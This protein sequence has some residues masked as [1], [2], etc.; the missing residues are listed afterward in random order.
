MRILVV[1]DE[2]L[3]AERLIELIE[4]FNPEYHVIDRLDS[5]ESTVS[6]LQK[7]DSPDL[8]FLD[9]H[10]ADG[11]S[12]E[13]FETVN[14]TA[15]IIFSTAYDQYAI[16]AFKVNSVDYLLK[17][18]EQKDLYQALIKFEKTQMSQSMSMNIGELV[19]SFTKK[20]KSRFVIKVGEHLRAVEI[21]NDHFF[22]SEEKI[23]YLQTNEGKRYIIDF[24]LDKVETMID[25][26]KY[27]RIN[28]KYLV[29]FPAIADI[30]THSNS[31]LR[32]V[33]VN[34]DD[35]DV[36]VSRERVQEFRSWL[37]V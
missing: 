37:D 12:F 10:L 29:S 18:V 14:V 23:T 33:L 15:P 1:E 16:Q 17:P 20:H 34:N 13:I 35:D 27:F 4:K 36:I 5:V 6:W 7:N 8:I 11:N 28:R 26:E 31:R 24:P 3:A 9:I 2:K 30:L 22:F 21:D 19:K 25:P 32:L